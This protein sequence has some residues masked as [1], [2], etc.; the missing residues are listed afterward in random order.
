[1]APREATRAELRAWPTTARATWSARSRWP[2][3]GAG[4]HGPAAPAPRHRRGADRARCAA[5]DPGGHPR[6]RRLPPGPGARRARRLPDH[7][8][9]GRAAGPPDERRAH[10][11]PLRDVASMLRSH[12]SRRRG[13]PRRRAE[14]EPRR[15]AVD[16]ARPGPRPSW[17]DRAPRAVPRGAT[18]TACARRASGSTPDPDLLLAFEVDKELYEFA[19]AATYLPSW[20]WAP[21][22]GMRALVGDAPMRRGHDRRPGR[23]VPR[24]HRRLARRPGPPARRWPPPTPIDP[25]AAAVPAPAWAARGTRPARRRRAARGVAHR[26]GRSCLRRRRAPTPRPTDL[27][28]VAIS[29]SGRTPEVVDAGRAPPRARAWSSR[30]PTDADSALAGRGRRGR[31]SCTPGPRPRGSPAGRSGRRS[32][33]WP[34]SPARPAAAL[35]DLPAALA[36]RLPASTDLGRRGRRRARRGA[37]HRR[38]RRRRRCSAWRSRRRSCSARRRAC[39]PMPCETADW[40]HVGVYLAWPGHVVLRI[41]GSAA[42]AEVERTLDARGV[43]RWTRHHWPLPATA[44]VVAAGRSWPRSTRSSWRSSWHGLA[45]TDVTPEADSKVP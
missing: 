3:A 30:S 20:L 24:R 42:D 15:P 32:R 10:R 39:R 38:P 43:R 25:G 6:P 29:A 28:V 41:P 45:A 18:A 8:L 19:Y 11:H 14:R 7:R 44:G 2:A 35:R 9:R 27:T 23:G 33:P 4:G 34:C 16:R 1:M 22:E 26:L 31:S 36:D 40:L 37:G 17:L 13:A 12:R 21:T 5:D